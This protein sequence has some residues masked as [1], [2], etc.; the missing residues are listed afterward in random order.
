MG[1]KVLQ[2]IPKANRK[3]QPVAMQYCKQLRGYPIMLIDCPMITN[4]QPLP[5]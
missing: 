3:V 1:A 5:A 2:D 4:F